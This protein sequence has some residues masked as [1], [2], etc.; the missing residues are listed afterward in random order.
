MIVLDPKQEHKVREVVVEGPFGT[1]DTLRNGIK[2]VSHDLAPK[3]PL[4]SHL[5]TVHDIHLDMGPLYARRWR[6]M[7]SVD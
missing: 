1:H 5:Q 3:H 4:Q 7:R 6:L 2:S